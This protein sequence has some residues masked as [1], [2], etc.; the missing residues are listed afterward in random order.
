M[1]ILFEASTISGLELPNRF[2]RSAT[3]EAMANKD[4]SCTSEL[5]A[6]MERLA[7][8][9][10][11][12]VISGYAYVLQN[13]QSSP[14]QLGVYSDG[15]IDSLSEMADAVHAHNGKIIMQITHAGVNANT[16]LTGQVP[17]GP[18]PIED[19]PSAGMSADQI[20]EVIEA[21]C[22]AA[23]RARKAGFDGVQIFAGHGYLLSQFL[24]PFYNK[25]MDEYGGC[26]DN[27]ARAVLEIVRGIRRHVGDDFPILIKL[28]SEDYLEGGLTLHE[29]LEVGAMLRDAGIDAIELSGGTWWSGDFSFGDKIPSRKRIISEDREAYFS[30]AAKAF[31]TEVDT[32]L[33]LVGGIR[34]FHVAERVIEEGMS[35]YVSMCRPLIREPELI[36]RWEGGDLSKALCISC[37]R[38]LEPGALGQAVYC[39]AEKQLME[40]ESSRRQNEV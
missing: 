30:Q 12:L 1:S 6:L 21:F 20:T 38:C 5:A 29:S 19:R 35:D 9:G 33:I 27:R 28:N 8:G 18:S 39:V 3:W 32:P 11:G 25:R 37:N 22:Q 40:R 23:I 7:L 2:I 26:L 4:G 17:L 10:V 24:S 16:A 15:L 14:K 34:S 13:G 36:S 31:K